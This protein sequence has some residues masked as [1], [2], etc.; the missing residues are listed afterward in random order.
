MK[1]GKKIGCLIAAIIF[2]IVILFAMP[3][4]LLPKSLYNVLYGWRYP[5][6]TSVGRAVMTDNGPACGTDRY[7]IP[8]GPV[9]LSIPG[10]FKA[11][12][13]RLPAVVFTIGIMVH[14]DEEK[15]I[16]NLN[17]LIDSKPITTIIDI[18]MA[19][20]RNETV[21]Q[22]CKPLNEWIWSGPYDEGVFVYLAG[23]ER[24]IPVSNGVS[25]IEFVG[26]K[27]DQ[28][29]GTYFIPRRSGEYFLEIKASG[30]QPGEG[31]QLS[32]E[33]KGGGWKSL[34]GL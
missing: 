6:T 12:L 19:N 22:E 34:P 11:Q 5:K 28:G 4:F 3:A 8:I 31:F 32:F 14:N 17:S 29:W 16:M 20:E 2:I 27:A 23:N 7:I 25:H 33:L 1:H 26:K 24:E 15:S 21:I 13:E 10:Q 18:R 30:A 9:N